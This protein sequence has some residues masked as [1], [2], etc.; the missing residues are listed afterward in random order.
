[1][2]VDL[3]SAVPQQFE[4]VISTSIIQRARTKG[5]IEIVVH[6]LHDYATDRFKHID[7]APYGGGA[8]MVLQCEPLFACIEG[9][10]DQRTYDEIIYLAPDGV[11]FQQSHANELSL[12]TNIMLLAGHYK[13]IDQRVRDTLITREISI[14]DYVLSG[15]ELPALVVLDALVRLLPG[16][17]S[18]AESA[19]DDSFMDGLL[20]APQYTRPAVFRDMPV[21]D[22]LLSGNHAKV[23]EW[24]LDQALRKTQER[25]PDLLP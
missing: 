20:S 5:I 25:R 2:R 16:A 17:I 3:L 7:D 18:D 1:M 22:V 4:S 21:P 19:L 12:K 23:R 13:G 24:R 15:G 8:G 6:N 9:L 14:G 10:M 11:P